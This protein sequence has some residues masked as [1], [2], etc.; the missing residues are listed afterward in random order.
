MSGI[1]QFK[2][3]F[4]DLA[5]PNRFEVSA[6]VL[7]TG[8]R[9]LAK[10]ASLPGAT[11]GVMET[12]YMGRMVKIA[13]DRVYAD[14][15]VTVYQDD[16]GTVRKAVEEWQKVALSHEQNIGAAAHLQYKEDVTVR[17]LNRQDSVIQ[18]YKLIGCFPTEI[19]LLDMAW[20]SN[21]TPAEFTI[22]LA[23]DYYETEGGSALGTAIGIGRSVLG[24]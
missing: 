13:G 4:L 10:A 3:S 20:D 24:V 7:G 15:D 6:S 12:P 2:G 5:R 8:L 21:D 18:E 19:G 1:N 16:R 11:L 22:T 14:W 17:Q 9:F 23:Y